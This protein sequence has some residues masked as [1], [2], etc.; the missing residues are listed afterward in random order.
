M[1]CFEPVL[2]IRPALP[3]A[4]M[5]GAK[6]RAPLMM[7]HM[8]TPMMRCQLSG[9][10]NSVLPGWMPALFMSR[11]VPPKRA[12]TARSSSVTLSARLTSTTNVITCAAG[13]RSDDSFVAAS[14][15]RPSSTSAMHTFMPDARKRRGRGKTDAGCAPGDHGDIAFG[16]DRMRHGDSPG[17]AV[18]RAITWRS[19]D[20][21]QVGMGGLRSTPTLRPSGAAVFC[22]T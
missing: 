15:S 21:A 10:P 2:M 22:L 19:R 17:R 12:R 7:P 9:S 13:P 6:M 5:S 14:A 4:I 8:L 20:P 1:P 3:R 18:G 16:D 11:S